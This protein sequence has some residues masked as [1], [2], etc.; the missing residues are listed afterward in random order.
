[1]WQISVWVGVAADAVIEGTVMSQSSLPA[2][3]PDWFAWKQGRIVGQKRPLLPRHVWAIR[4]R[5]EIGDRFR[6][7]ASSNTAMDSNLCRCDLAKLE[8]ADVYAA[9]QVKKRFSVNRA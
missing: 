6:N 1:M 5:T 7:F 3:R 9:G 4:V 2:I 8:V